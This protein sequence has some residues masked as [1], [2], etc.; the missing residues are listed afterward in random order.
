MELARAAD[1][2]VAGRFRLTKRIGKGAFGDIYHSIDI[3]TNEEVATK[4][5]DLFVSIGIY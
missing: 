3:K 4:L 5:V 1:V 2:K